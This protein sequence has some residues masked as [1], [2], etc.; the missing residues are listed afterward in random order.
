MQ[1]ALRVS[2]RGGLSIFVIFFN[3]TSNK[4]CCEISRIAAFRDARPVAFL[5]RIRDRSVPHDCQGGGQG[6]NDICGLTL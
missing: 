3:F 5:I 6:A 2:I 4:L 1:V